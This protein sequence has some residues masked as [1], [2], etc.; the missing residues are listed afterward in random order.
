VADVNFT[1]ALGAAERL[2]GTATPPD[3]VFAVSDVYAAAVEKAAKRK[4]LRVPA[5]LAVVGFDNI[6]VSLMCDPSIT[7][8]NQPS[9]EIGAF[10]CDMLL[11]RI[12]APETPPR[13]LVLN[14][15]LIVRESTM[16]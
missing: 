2:L 11:E 5:D 12:R 8:V 9:Y 1:L 3:A 7:T 13:H 16:R 10:A 14:T 4:G 15:E 6:E